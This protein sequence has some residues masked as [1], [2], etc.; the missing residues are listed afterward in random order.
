MIEVTEHARCQ[1]QA[2]LLLTK[3]MQ[4][5]TVCLLVA[6]PLEQT[7]RRAVFTSY[8]WKQVSNPDSDTHIVFQKAEELDAVFQYLLLAVD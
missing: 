2:Y 3:E 4:T 8:A 5:H 7:Q 6:E 1:E